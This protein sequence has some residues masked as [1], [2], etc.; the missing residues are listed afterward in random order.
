MK[1]FYVLAFLLVASVNGW[2]QLGTISGTVV[3]LKTKEPIIGGNVV[4]QGTT[5]GS[6]TDVEGNYVINSVKP[7]T[8]TLVVS[9]VAYKT[10]TVADVVVES[11]KRTTV[12]ITLV[13]DVAELAEV[14]V[15]ATREVNNDVSLMQGIKQAK[16]VVSG[17]S[18][19]QIT[20]LPDRDAAQIAQ[21][22]PGIT[23]ADNR[24]VVVRGLPQRYNQ[25]MINGAIGPSTETDSRSFSF[26]LIPA[27]FI[28]QMLIYKSGTAELPGDFAGG[29]IQIVTKQPEIENF[30]KV[31]FSAGF[32][33]GTT[34]QN[35]R[36]SQTSSTDWLGFDNGFR[37]LPADF[38]TTTALRA[39]NRTDINRERAGKSLNN[40]F[41]LK[42]FQAPIDL[43]FNITTSNSFRI[44][45]V[46]AKN[47]TAVG[48]SN[49][50][51]TFQAEFN[52]FNEFSNG[53]LTPRFKYFDNTHVRETRVSAMHNWEFKFNDRHKLEFKNFFVQL[54]EN[55]TIVREGNDFIQQPNFDRLNYSYYYLD[56]SIYSGQLQGFHELGS[57]SKINWVVG[58][59]LINK[60]E[61]DFRRFRTFRDIADR[62]TETPYEMQLPPNS[63][64]FDTG[65][66]W[67]SLND[68]GLNHSL[69]F[70]HKFGDPKEKR[71]ASIKAGYLFEYRTR[72][73]DAR[74]ISYLYPG[75]FDQTIKQ[76]LALLPISDIFAPKNISRN[77]GLVIEE[78]T[79]LTDSYT[80]SNF[81]TAGYVGGTLPVGKFDLAGGVRIENNVQ[82][83]KAFG[84]NVENT[85]LAPLPFL[86]VAFNL[87]ERELIRAA[88]SRTLNR[89]EFRELAPFLFYQFEVDANIVGTPTLKTAFINNLDL[90]YE[91]Y[92][93]PGEMFSI[94][95]FYKS[96]KDPIE[97]YNQIVGESPQ[98]FYANSPEAYSVGAEIEFR[99]SLASLG[100]SKFLRNT[101]IN[102]NAAFI[103]S[104]VD[105]GA[106]A[107]NQARFRPLTG[108]SPYIVNV[109]VYYNDEENGFSA[110]VAYNV[111]GQ[112]IFTVGDLLYPTWFEMPRNILDLQIAKQFKKKYEIKFNAQNLLNA[113]Y[114]FKQ[115][116]ANDS[117][118][119]NSDPLIR[120]YRIGAQYSISFSV[121]FHHGK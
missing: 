44:G 59:N 109:G 116:N 36:S 2:A 95:A 16:L 1:N 61:P 15:T 89:P 14:V 21:R 60:R 73:F 63:N 107:T 71:T 49:S 35:F 106:A 85:V 97:I 41:A 66:F 6:S 7:G 115:D 42:E 113:N 27:G 72:A 34:F 10:Q 108:Q 68:D 13:E 53:V 30:T 103:K 99:K 114:Q 47:L 82:K 81:L 79:N 23:I 119:Q 57:S 69:N 74:Y 8:Y 45:K 55:R 80:G 78:G 105:V 31:G 39:T 93:N 48:Y 75:N 28:D 86:N 20:K 90:R 65:R 112:R 29:V 70:E 77:N 17:I 64:L 58:A 38:P 3:D 24:F 43:G 18:A 4:I 88:Y 92:P 52:R 5:V 102:T 84:V 76:Q 96:F 40:T 121:K 54:G 12:N 62:G 110:N 9:Y 33:D 98:F 120:G 32:R 50:Y 19:E 94:G 87:S 46:T 101:S 51:Q 67:S 37:E 111:F 100:V 25:V 117:E 56:R 26:D 104:E 83:L 22:V 11:G 118:I 91:M